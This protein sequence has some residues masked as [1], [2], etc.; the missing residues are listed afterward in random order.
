[1]PGHSQLLNTHRHGAAAALWQAAPPGPASRSGAKD[2][3]EAA[4]AELEAAMSA[5]RRPPGAPVCR[6]PGS[7]RRPIVADDQGGAADAAAPPEPRPAEQNTE[8]K[9]APSDSGMRVPPQDSGE[10]PG[11]EGGGRVAR[12]PQTVRCPVASRCHCRCGPPPGLG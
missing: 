3:A 2:L 1:M 10:T 5:A 12:S 4:I 9:G 11:E 6:E 8:Q 7:Q